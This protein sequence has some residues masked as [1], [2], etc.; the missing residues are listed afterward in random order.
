MNEV[1]KLEM[2]FLAS[3]VSDGVWFSFIFFYSALFIRFCFLSVL[4]RTLLFLL[5]F[6]SC[7]SLTSISTVNDLIAS[8]GIYLI[9]GVQ[10]GAFNR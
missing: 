4:A 1:N 5:S 3:I 7:P 10:E 9:L 2:E 8:Q 6:F